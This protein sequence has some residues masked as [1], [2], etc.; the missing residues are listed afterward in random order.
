MITKTMA[1]RFF[2]NLSPEGKVQAFMV[3]FEQDGMRIME[4][5]IEQ[6]NREYPLEY[7]LIRGRE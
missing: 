1:K 2:E 6:F 5:Y 7:A 4:G 3:L